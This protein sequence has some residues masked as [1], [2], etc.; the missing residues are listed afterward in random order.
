ML[1]KGFGRLDSENFKVLSPHLLARLRKTTKNS[2][3]IFG[4]QADI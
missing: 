3:R 4:L 1:R 2:L